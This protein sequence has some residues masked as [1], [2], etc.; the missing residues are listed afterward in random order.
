VQPTLG[1]QAFIRGA[2]PGK[3]LPFFCDDA[4]TT[5]AL[6]VKEFIEQTT[7][8]PVEE[9][10]LLFAGRELKDT[11]TLKSADVVEGS[12]MHL[13]LRGEGGAKGLGGKDV[14]GTKRDMSS[15]TV[16]ATDH[17]LV[18]DVLRL[19]EFDVIDWL[20]EMEPEAFATLNAAVQKERNGDR[21]LAALVPHVKE[22]QDL[23]EMCERLQDRLEVARANTKEVLKRSLCNGNYYD[24]TTGVE[25]KKLKTLLSGIMTVKTSAVRKSKKSR[26]SSP[27][28]DRTSGAAGSTDGSTRHGLFSWF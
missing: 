14:G 22:L 18:K 8:I 13:A 28:E 1:H 5:T 17:R 10:R 16:M 9:Q 20:Q 21:V 25:V 15:F 4:E 7:M 23:E 12:D 19:Q 6:Q 2:L 24:E 11:D 27:D 3:R 26:A